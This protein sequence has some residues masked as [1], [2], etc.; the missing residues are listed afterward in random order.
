VPGI[1]KVEKKK[2]NHSKTDLECPCH[3]IEGPQALKTL[4]TFRVLNN[5]DV[6]WR[7]Q[8]KFNSL[9]L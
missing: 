3:C 7:K 9:A 2:T 6:E 1:R 4:Y 8:N 5:N